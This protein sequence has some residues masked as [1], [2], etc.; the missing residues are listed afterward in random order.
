MPFN[1]PKAREAFF[2]T[3]AKN[4]AGGGLGQP[5]KGNTAPPASG[6]FN[7]MMKAAITTK[8]AFQLGSNPK[9]PR[10]TQLTSMFK[11]GM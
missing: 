10:F 4:N 8:P 1:N 7:P 6:T 2:A 3:Q 11:K 5:F 9:T